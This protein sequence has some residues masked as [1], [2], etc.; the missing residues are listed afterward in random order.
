MQKIMSFLI[1]EIAA[2]IGIYAPISKHLAP[3]EARDLRKLRRCIQILSGA[4]PDLKHRPKHKH[5]G[6]LA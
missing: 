1:M 3:E 2:I 6:Q 5:P 4:K